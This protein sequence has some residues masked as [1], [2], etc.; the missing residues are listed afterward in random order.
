MTDDEIKIKAKLDALKNLQIKKEL[1]IKIETKEEVEYEN[2]QTGSLQKKPALDPA[3]NQEQSPRK[4]K[5]ENNDDRPRQQQPKK[6]GDQEGEEKDDDEEEDKD[7]DENPDEEKDGE[8]EEDEGGEEKG[9]EG[10]DEASSEEQAQNKVADQTEQLLKKDVKGVAKKGIW[11]LLVAAAPWLLPA[12]GILSA[13]ILVLGAAMFILVVMIAKCNEDSWTGTAVRA[14]SWIGIIPGDICA[15]LAISTNF[16][17]ASQQAPIT[18][19]E[20]SDLV[21]LAGVLV[22]T[23]ARDPRV[24]QCMLSKVQSIMNTARASGIDVVITSAFRKGDFPSR[25][26][27]G[28]AVDIALRP[29]PSRPFTNEARGKIA[30]LVQIAKSAGFN[31]PLGDTLDEYNNPIEGRTT[32][33]H[34]HIEFNKI[35]VNRSHCAPY[36]NAPAPAT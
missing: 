25:H 5:Q 11:E 32:G 13:I 2:Q 16:Q 33:G 7:E 26:A 31:P 12:L 36:P 24:R 3:L 30:Q 15:Q 1:E 28:E 8:E 4:Q 18:G 22:D 20:P 17:T 19:W 21:P 14:A 27:F 10:D 9:K 35:D 23:E 6:E 34:V 29:V